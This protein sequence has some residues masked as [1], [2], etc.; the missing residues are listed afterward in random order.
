MSKWVVRKQPHM[1]EWYAFLDEGLNVRWVQFSSWREAM[2]FLD[3]EARTAKVTLPAPVPDPPVDVHRPAWHVSE[4][5][6]RP[7]V[8][9]V[10]RYV[11][12]CDRHGWGD[13]LDADVAEKLGLALLAAAMHAKGEQP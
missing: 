2:R 1:D 11:S 4:S 10:G 9:P 3:R 8:A 6:T 13:H 5:L 12:T 7:W